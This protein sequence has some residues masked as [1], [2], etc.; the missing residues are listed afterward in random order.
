VALTINQMLATLLQ[1]LADEIAAAGKEEDYCTVTVQPGS[2]VAIDFGPESGCGGTAWVQLVG[3]NPSVSFPS[4]DVGVNN[5]AYDLAFVVEVGMVGPAPG[6]DVTL[7]Q[8]TVPE[9]TELF[10]ASMRQMDELQMMYRAIQKAKIPEKVVGSYAP[11]GPDGGVLGG[12]W[13]VT[14]GGED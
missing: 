11:Q 7:G 12:V 2:A 9:D 5:C 8:Y 13:T 3:A 10:D 4:A 6:M 1:A 14:V